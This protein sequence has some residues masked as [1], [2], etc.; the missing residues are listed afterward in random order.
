ML[1]EYCRLLE[2]WPGLVSRGESIEA[3]A[4]DSLELVP[5]LAEGET[6]VDVGSGGGMPGIPLK[7]AL[8][9]L[10]LTLVEA[11][12]K[13]ASFLVFALAR[14]GLAD[15]E[16]VAAR[17]EEVA[18]GGLR[19]RFDAACSRALAAADVAAELCLPLVRVGG[20]ALLMTSGEVPSAP[21]LRRLGGQVES[22]TP[23]PSVA[24]AR[25][26][27]VVVRKLE[28]TPPAWPRRAGVPA[29]RPL[30]REDS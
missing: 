19:E 21:A 25:G 27:V 16:V 2:G 20:R 22:V 15:V 23:T 6:L 1:Q 7:L 9:S 13:K 17:A 5:F 18:R 4:Q 12:R 14:L 30:G 24:R 3:L 8:P 11:D 28:A 10:R 26:H 29:R